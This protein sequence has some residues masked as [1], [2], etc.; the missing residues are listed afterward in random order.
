MI[1]HPTLTYRIDLVERPKGL[2]DVYYENLLLVQRSND[3]EFDACRKLLKMGV[4]GVLETYTRGGQVPRMRVDIEKGSRLSTEV[5][6][7]KAFRPRAA[8]R[9]DRFEG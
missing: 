2:Y 9:T 8:S 6:Y 7:F 5:P 3:P 1:D 4:T